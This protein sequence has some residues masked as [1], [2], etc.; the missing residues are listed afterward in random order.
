MTQK[1]VYAQ[2]IMCD[3]LIRKNIVRKNQTHC[4]WAS[5]KP[6]PILPTHKSI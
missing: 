2:Q 4:H 6:S 5:I 1:F 3:R